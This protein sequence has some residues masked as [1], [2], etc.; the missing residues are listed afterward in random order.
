MTTLNPIGYWH[1]KNN[2]VTWVYN[3][4]LV[5]KQ[6][7]TKFGNTMVEHDFYIKYVMPRIAKVKAPA[8]VISIHDNVKY[9]LIKDTVGTKANPEQACHKITIPG[10]KDVINL[11]TD[12][13]AYIYPVCMSG[14][15]SVCNNTEITPPTINAHL[16]P[17][18]SGKNRVTSRTS[19][20]SKGQSAIVHPCPKNARPFV[21]AMRST[22]S[23]MGLELNVDNTKPSVP[24]AFADINLNVPGIV[25][26]GLLSNA[27]GGTGVSLNARP[28]VNAVRSTPLEGGLELSVDGTLDSDTELTE[29]EELDGDELDTS[30]EEEEGNTT[31]EEEE[32]LEE[33]GDEDE[34]LGEEEEELGEEEEELAE[35][36]LA[37]EELAEEEEEL[38]EEEED[39]GEEDEDGNIRYASKKKKPAVK[40]V[41]IAE[42]STRGR[43]KYKNDQTFNLSQILK[44][45]TWPETTQPRPTTDYNKYRQHIVTIL[46]NDCNPTPSVCPIRGNRIIQSQQIEM[47]IYNYSVK[48]SQKTYIFAHWEN[49][50]FVSIYLNKAK[51]I[52]SNLCTK[53]GVKN[54]QIWDNITKNKI[55]LLTI[56]DLSYNELWPENWQAIKDEQIKIEQMRKEAIQASATDMFKCPRCKK[57]NC[58][59]F[60]LQTR[61]AD[62]PMTIFITCLE[63]G[64]KWKQN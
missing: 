47:S 37:E 38:A 61:S 13:D 56:A 46:A 48:Q 18:A 57:C 32:A 55:N 1:I 23:D 10:N 44:V 29:D 19:G 9:I 49:P 30:S 36:E 6:T 24:N 35:E 14:C 41:V 25:D 2:T 59:Y 26:T 51:S 63:C 53:F 5:P 34:E 60:E 43:K 15:I 21:N 64:L 20:A 42:T 54:T 4:G 16:T 52:I 28:F 45:E 62:E 39:A 12:E 11:C 8:Y 17:L 3:E 40:K 31:A 58:T 7:F 27:S 50:I 33:L 22:A